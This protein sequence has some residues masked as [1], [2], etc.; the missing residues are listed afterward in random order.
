MTSEEMELG[1]RSH[2]EF[3]EQGKLEVVDEIYTKDCVIYGRNIPPEWR[4]G[5]AGFKA[6]GQMLHAA[7][8]DIKIRHDSTVTQ[9]EYQSIRWTFSGTHKGPLFGA[10]PTGK[11]VEME[12]YDILRIV[13]GRISEMW[14]E[15]DMLSLLQQLGLA[16]APGQAQAAA[17]R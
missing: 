7:F 4:H 13:N 12:G 2:R 6:Y 1:L 11:S 10:P 14:V 8:P 9:G 17:A 5:T 3:I 15:Q 16:P